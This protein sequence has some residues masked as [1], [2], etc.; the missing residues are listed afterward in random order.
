MIKFRQFVEDKVNFNAARTTWQIRGDA[1]HHPL[2][3]EKSRVVM[4]DVEPHVDYEA[5]AEGKQVYAYLKGDPVHHE[6]DLSSHEAHP[7]AFK[8]GDPDHPFVHTSNQKPLKKADYVVF[9][10]KKTT[11]YYKK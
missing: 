5:H 7:V 11:A 3:R 6:P 1:E 9:D 10:G 2:K 4:K 8:R